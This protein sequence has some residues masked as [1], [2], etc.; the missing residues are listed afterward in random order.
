[1]RSG[2]KISGLR[3]VDRTLG[4]LPKAVAKRILR[5][6]GVDALQPVAQSMR[7]RAPRDQGDLEKGIT[8]G[9]ALTRSQKKHSG[10]GGGPRDPNMVVVYT[11]PGPH[12]QAVLQ[13]IGT[14]FHPPQPY[15]APAFDETKD[16]V[17]TFVSENLRDRVMA[18]AARAA[19]KGKLRNA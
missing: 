9:T 7:A 14:S 16:G 3:D 11:G 2:V 15:V 18:A 4:Q 13:E 1:M 19:K 5:T 8:V 6:V 10:L 12:P 17:V